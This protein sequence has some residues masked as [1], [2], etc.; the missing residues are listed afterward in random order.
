[1]LLVTDLHFTDKEADRYRFKIFTWIHE[2]FKKTGDKNLIILG[3]LTDSK[4]HHSAN[5]VNSIIK[6]MLD[7]TDAGMEIFVLKGNHDYINPDLPFFGFLERFEWI[8]FISEPRC[9]IIEGQKCLFLPHSRNPIGEWKADKTVADNRK[10]AD[11]VFMH[12]SV[13]GSVTSSGY[14]MEEGLLPSYF[15]RFKG[16]VFSGDIH[17]PQQISCVTYVGTPYSIRFND[18]FRGRAISIRGQEEPV[19]LFPDIRRRWTLDINS[20]DDLCNQLNEMDWMVD[21]QL[22]I[23]FALSEADEEKWE[24][25]RKTIEKECAAR[26]LEVCSLQVTRPEKLPLRGRKR[27]ELQKAYDLVLPGRVVDTFAKHRGLSKGQH[28]A[29]KK[30][31]ENAE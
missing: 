10:T 31:L 22:K 21:D 25:T 28:K 17:C 26:E 6:R 13:I 5:L 9:I 2:Y 16:Q 18:H 30:L 20:A 29:G 1:M 24:R 27:S 11:F 8:R 19:E 3:D 12:E 4:D 15:R 14:E 7:L 23:R